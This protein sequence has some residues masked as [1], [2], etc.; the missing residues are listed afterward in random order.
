[1]NTGLPVVL[2]WDYHV[3]QRGHLNAEIDRRKADVET[4]FTSR[5]QERVAAVLARYHVALVYVGPLERRTYGGANLAN[6][7]RWKELLTPLYE[8]P[9]VQIFAVNGNFVGAI[10]APVVEVVPENAETKAQPAAQQQDPPGI[11]RQPRGVAC[12]RE[13]NVYVADFGNCR[14]QELGPDLA[15][16]VAWGRRGKNPGEFQDP[17]GVAI[18]PDGLLY[19][20]DTWNARVQVFDRTGALSREWSAELYGARGIAV[21]ST[22]A[23]YVADTGN[24][25]ICRFSAEGRLE[26]SWGGRGSEPGMLNDPMG[27]AVDGSGHVLVCDNSNSRLQVFDRD[28]KL[29]RVIA[30][31]DWRREVFGEPFVA[32][33]DD[34]T[35]WVTV[36]LRDQVRQYSPQGAL[37]RTIVSGE[38]G[39]PVIR[40]P[41]GIAISPDGTQLIVSTK[42]GGVRRI[43]TGARPHSAAA[44]R[45]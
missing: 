10:S 26:K 30:V 1:M 35:I 19:V 31:P 7:R 29:L 37:L 12:D 43:E 17:C 20:A 24:A 13:G 38:D 16:R 39:A 28:G 8:N 25:R 3:F 34:Q 2:G 4:I 33:A 23:V 32:V 9:A 22:G 45:P 18:G 5:S 27:L 44:R 15:P 14:I 40:T 42:D 11:L 21:D 41:L 6:F 36:P